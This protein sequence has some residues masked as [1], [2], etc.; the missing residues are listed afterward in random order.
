MLMFIQQS[1]LGKFCYHGGSPQ[2]MYVCENTSHNTTTWAQLHYYH[3][4]CVVAGATYTRYTN[5][6]RKLPSNRARAHD[7]TVY[8]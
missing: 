2:I 3:F 4:N 5:T 7:E 1:L 8:R 6:H